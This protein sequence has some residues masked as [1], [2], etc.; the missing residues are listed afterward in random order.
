[1]KKQIVISHFGGV[2]ATAK[3]LGVTSQAVSQW[4]DLIPKG[5]ALMAERIS[6]KRLK[7]DEDMYEKKG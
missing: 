3:A 2:V 6:N 7:F 4:G 5:Q 1:M